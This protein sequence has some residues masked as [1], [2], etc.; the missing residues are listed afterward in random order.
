MSELKSMIRGLFHQDE[1][2]PSTLEQQWKTKHDL[3]NFAATRPDFLARKNNMYH[4]LKEDKFGNAQIASKN[5]KLDLERAYNRASHPTVR[6]SI[7][8]SIQGLKDKS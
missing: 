5:G 3:E 6:D 4:L 8:L 2:K 7:F 1:K